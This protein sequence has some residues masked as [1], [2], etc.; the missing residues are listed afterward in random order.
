MIESDSTCLAK[1]HHDVG[2]LVDKGHITQRRFGNRHKRQDHHNGEDEPRE[3][4]M[5]EV[6]HKTLLILFNRNLLVFIL[7][8]TGM[9]LGEL[10]DEAISAPY[11][12]PFVC[13]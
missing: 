4:I 10:S 5:L 9:L 12:T 13:C 8:R 6:V 3:G 11:G 1:V 7:K 2:P